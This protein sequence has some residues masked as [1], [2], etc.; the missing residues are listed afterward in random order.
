MTQYPDW[1][2]AL[3]AANDPTFYPLRY[4]DV[5]FASRQVQ[6]WGTDR[7]AIL[8]WLK[9][10]PGGAFTCETFAAAGDPAEMVEVLKPEIEAWARAMGCTNCLITAGRRGMARLHSDYTHYQTILGKVLQ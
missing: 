1:R 2:E 4:Q 7:A 5:L 9:H 10:Y 6:F 8:T 3:A